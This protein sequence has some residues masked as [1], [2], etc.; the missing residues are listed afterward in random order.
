MVAGK[1]VRAQARRWTLGV[2]CLVVSTADRALL[3]LLVVQKILTDR[4]RSS[5]LA[6]HFL[7]APFAMQAAV[8]TRVSNRRQLYDHSIPIWAKQRV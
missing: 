1:M 7:R 3:R 5:E 8:Y 2:G 6:L 4:V